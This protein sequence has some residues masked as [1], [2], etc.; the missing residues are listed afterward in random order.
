MKLRVV[1]KRTDALCG[2]DGNGA[3]DVGAEKMLATR[4]A[5]GGSACFV[6][7][8]SL[9]LGISEEFFALEELLGDGGNVTP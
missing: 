9:G 4:L 8:R 3:I 6:N 1:I 7:R 5:R 2:L